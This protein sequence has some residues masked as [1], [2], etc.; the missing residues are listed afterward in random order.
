M[1]GIWTLAANLK[2]IHDGLK[3]DGITN[4]VGVTDA[5]IERLTL[6]ALNSN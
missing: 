1:H 2:W 6:E 4:F 3:V 5:S